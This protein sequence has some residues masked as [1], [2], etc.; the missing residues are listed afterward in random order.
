MTPA[1]LQRSLAAYADGELAVELRAEI[2][3]HLAGDPD[4]RA[5][6]QR[7]Q[8]L[9]RTTRR[10]LEA[11]VVPDGLRDRILGAL[12]T[13][14]PAASRRWRRRIIGLTTAVAAAAVLMVSWGPLTGRSAVAAPVVEPELVAAI[15][16]HCAIQH[17]HDPYHLA[18]RT[19]TDVVAALKQRGSCDLGVHL[20]DLSAA[21][22][23]FAGVCD[24]PERHEFGT[25]HAYYKRAGQTPDEPEQVVSVFTMRPRCRMPGCTQCGAAGGCQQHRERQ[26]NVAHAPHDVTVVKWEGQACGF[27]VCGKLP[28]ADLLQLVDGMNVA[29]R[30]APASATVAQ[31]SPASTALGGRTVPTAVAL[32]VGA[33]SLA[34]LC[35][36][37]RK[38]ALLRNAAVTSRRDEPPADTPCGWR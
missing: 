30:W 28:E 7:W 38:V 19:R 29:G 5:I 1:E 3:G 2:A 36:T 4:S 33:L 31:L 16:E 26:Y 22:Y 12:S 15:H 6:V 35:S 8:A 11:E 34:T 10:V 37:W 20:P 25:L 32:L 9:R 27:A 18:G 24:C 14:R 17:H 23:Q 21:G 13:Q